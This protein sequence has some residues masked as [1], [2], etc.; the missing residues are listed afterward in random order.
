MPLA[1]RFLRPFSGGAAAPGAPLSDGRARGARWRTPGRATCA[2]CATASSARPSSRAAPSSPPEDLELGLAAL[3]RDGADA[4]RGDRTRTS[5]GR[6]R[7]LLVTGGSVSRAAGRLGV[8]RQALYRRM[9][10]L[11]IDLE[12][13]PAS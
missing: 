8:S 5:A 13:R 6:W 10:R 1:E 11:G 3:P 7:R 4:G 12:R 2:S 9:E